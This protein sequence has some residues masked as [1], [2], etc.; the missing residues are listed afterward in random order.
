MTFQNVVTYSVIVSVENR[1]Q[2]LFPGMTA[3]ARILVEEQR[4]ILRV[5]N[6]ALRYLPKDRQPPLVE[7]FVSEGGLPA[8]VWRL[9][10]AGEPQPVAIRTGANDDRYSA[11]LSGPLQEGDALIT[12]ENADSL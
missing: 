5:P 2:A 7:R 10:P 11:L 12:G 3:V 1:D 4:D 9:D 6:A 8:T